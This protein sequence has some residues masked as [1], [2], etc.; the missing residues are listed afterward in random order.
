M[1][2][3]VQLPEDFEDYLRIDNAKE[4]MEEARE[5]ARRLSLAG[6]G[7]RPNADHYAIFCDP[8]RLVAGPLKHVGYVVGLDNRCYPS[9][10]DGCDYINVAASL[11]AASPARDKGWPDHVAVVH[12][13]DDVACD[14]MI[15]QGYGNP[16]IHHITWSIDLP[17]PLPD[18]EIELAGALVSRM[19]AVRGQ[20]GG[21]LGESPGTLIIAL[22]RDVLESPGFKQHFS[23]WVGATP[24][25]EYQLEIM[26]GGGHLLQFFVLKGGRIEVAMRFGTRQ[27]F[28]PKSVHKISKDELSVNQGHEVLA[29]ET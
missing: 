25:D 19:A 11:P 20:I 17:S 15:G 29:A 4:R 27:T 28:N 7:L 26:Q 13:V 8:P 18:S 23:G 24:K 12:P 6:I 21:L 16:F 9:P 22:T 1:N 2:S 3:M 5:V 10:V 14:R